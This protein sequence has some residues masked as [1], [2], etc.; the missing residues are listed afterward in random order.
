MS[1]I[2]RSCP[3]CDAYTSNVGIAFRD[4]Q[5]CPYC[6]LPAEAALQLDLARERGAQRETLEMAAK[7]EA[8]AAR[9]EAEVARL[10]GLVNE[11]LWTAER[12]DKES[13]HAG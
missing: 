10:R 8:R 13:G 5:P 2:K 12:A 7:A 4:D 11:I 9:A 3:A 6:G 1:D